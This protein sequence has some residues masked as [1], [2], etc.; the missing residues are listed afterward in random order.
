MSP[1]LSFWRGGFPFGGV[2]PP[3]ATLSVPGA[4]AGDQLGTLMGHEMHFGDVTGDG[5]CPSAGSLDI[6]DQL[7]QPL[8][9]AGGQNY[10]RPG[11]GEAQSR[12]FSDS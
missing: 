9:T 8:G 11:F 7:L 4:S 1:S 12:R 5:R 3:N 6:P 2:I 10:G